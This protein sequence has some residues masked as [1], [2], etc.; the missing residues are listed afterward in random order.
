MSG[1]SPS[2]WMDRLIGWCFGI[3]GAVIALYCAVKVLEAIWP[4]LVMTVGAVALIALIIRTVVYY[5]SKNS[6]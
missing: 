3:L 1:E 4:A 2:R 6:W 5:T